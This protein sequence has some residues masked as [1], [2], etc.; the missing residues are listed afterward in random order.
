MPRSLPW[1][2]GGTKDD[3]TKQSTPRPR[4]V[5]P[6]TT[7]SG[8]GSDNARK[9]RSPVKETPK[10]TD[11]LRSSRSPSSSPIRQPPTEEF[12]REGFD[13]DDMYIMVE[14]EFYAVAQTF[15]RHLHHAEYVRRRKQAK[16]ENATAIKD[17]ARPTDGKTVMRK[18]TKK[19]KESEELASRQRKGLDE[20]RGK[21]PRVDSE[22][23]ASD[24]DEEEDRDDDPWVGTSL[25][26]L[27]TSP[28]KSRS[29]VGLQG[30]KSS[31]RAAAGYRQAG[32]NGKD[33]R[34]EPSPEPRRQEESHVDETAS[35]DDDDLEVTQVTS[36]AA[37][38]PRVDSMKARAP[39][40]RETPG[41]PIKEENRD[42]GK[43][44]G[45]Y[46]EKK[47]VSSSSRSVYSG[48]TSSNM[49]T[50]KRRLLEEL[51][52]FPETSEGRSKDRI[53][54]QPQ[55]SLSARVPS[56]RRQEKDSKKSRFSEVPTFLV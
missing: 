48:S 3:T 26:S 45:H 32:S 1:L 41:T 8:S 28:R 43:S 31:T 47:A 55:N 18:E 44:N 54:D 2:V 50:R 17:L 29:L 33:D 30:I 12:L 34:R 38:L 14:D 10:K 39:V 56:P 37:P 51:D 22:E 15:T 7:P 21:R 11:F 24:L 36:K 35:E 40:K 25:H 23:E 20:T 6:D 49:N 42:V 16:L 19:Q 9:R 4:R 46:S 5:S 27:M 52:D 53:Q 13:N